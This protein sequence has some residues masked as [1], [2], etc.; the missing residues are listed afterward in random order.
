[1][2]TFSYSGPSSRVHVETDAQ[3]GKKIYAD[4]DYTFVGLPDL[5]LGSDYI[6][7]ANADKLYNAVDLMQV[8]VKRGALVA[9]AHDDRLP[10]PGWLARQFSVTDLTLAV[11]GQSMR[12]FEHRA[13]SDESLTLG[14]NAE[15]AKL[16][17]C[18]M[19][20]VFVSA[21]APSALLEGDT[22]LSS[23]PGMP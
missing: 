17:S 16:K 13:D 21:A 12:I 23:E 2:Q 22:S 8:T 4:R 7:T 14:V 11:N 10:R 3:D 19:Y 15:N 6:Q 1:M 9:V 18:N 20:V 5:L